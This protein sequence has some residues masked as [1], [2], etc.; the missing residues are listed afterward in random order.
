[1]GYEART[2]APRSPPS[3]SSAPLRSGSPVMH[4]TATDHPHGLATVAIDHEG[5]AAQSFDLV[6]D[7]TLVGYQL[8]RAHRRGH[9]LRPLERVRLR[10]LPLHIPIQRNGQRLPPAGRA[11]GADDGRPDSRRAQRPV[12]RGRRRMSI[13]CSDTTSVHRPAFFRIVDGKLA[14]QVRDV[15]YRPRQPSFGRHG[16]RRRRSTYRLGGAFQLR[17]GPAGQVPGE[18][19][20]PLGARKRV[21]VL[22]TT[23]ESGR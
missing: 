18:P 2:Q 9:R 16:G 6:R 19:R 10:R 11:G 21:R 4:V 1:M 23:A 12:H 17:Q 7:G 22:N 3:T 15:A 14:G 20:L 5:V 13:D 8:D